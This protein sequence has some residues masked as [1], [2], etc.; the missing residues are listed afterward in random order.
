[1]DKNRAKKATNSLEFL[2]TFPIL[3]IAILLV[4]WFS[5]IFFF[6]CFAGAVSTEA[7]S[8]DS[9]TFGDGGAFISSKTSPFNASFGYNT[10]KAG[11]FVM[12]SVSGSVSEDWLGWLGHRT[13]YFKTMTVAP[14]WEF[15]P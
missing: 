3:W 5:F 14:V 6:K 12:T 9:I 11:D 15:K 2:A 13:S 7:A 8:R 10:T 4:V 1:M